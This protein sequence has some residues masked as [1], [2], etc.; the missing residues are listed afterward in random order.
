MESQAFSCG[1]EDIEVELPK[2]SWIGSLS[3]ALGADSIQF[4]ETSGT[5]DL[6]WHTAPCRQFIIM[7]AGESFFSKGSPSVFCAKQ[8]SCVPHT[9]DEIGAPTIFCR[10]CGRDDNRWCDAPL[11]GRGRPAGGG[12]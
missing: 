5:Y 11:C 3:E 1:A 4:R 9:M 10:R 7:S 8:L 6:G 12:H 2:S